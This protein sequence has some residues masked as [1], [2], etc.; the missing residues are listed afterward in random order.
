[1]QYLIIKNKNK[2][3]KPESE[4]VHVV[5]TLINLGVDKYAFSMQT[6]IYSWKSIHIATEGLALKF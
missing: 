2:N 6:F 5:N 1:M 3:V 4:N